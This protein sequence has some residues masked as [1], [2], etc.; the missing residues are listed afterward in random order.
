MGGNLALVSALEGTPYAV[1]MKD[2]IL[3]LEDVREAPYRIDR[4]L[5]QLELAGRLDGL[6][7]AILGQFTRAFDR[8]SDRR[9]EDPRF[10]VD[11]VL[12]QYFEHRGIP[13]IANFPVGH[14]EMN[15]T[16]PIGD[17]VE[18]DADEKVVR[19]LGGVAR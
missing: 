7:G 6:R 8:E 15:A 13:V 2:A 18:V 17:W 3:L 14:H 1:D 4:M 5:R 9:E 12:A 10:Q 16:L 11:G 19:V